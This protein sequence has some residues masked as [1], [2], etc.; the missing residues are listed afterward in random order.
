M[1]KKDLVDNLVEVFAGITKKDMEMVV[2]TFFKSITEGLARGEAID[3]RGLGR[4][5]VRKRRPIRGRNPRTAKHVDLPERWVVHFKPSGRL[6]QK[7]RK[8]PA[9]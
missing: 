4:L 8:G 1:V 7:D 3:L 2:K 9:E 6:V 5:T